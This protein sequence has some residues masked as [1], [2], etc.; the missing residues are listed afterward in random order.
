MFILETRVNQELG[1]GEGPDTQSNEV[2]TMP[3]K[4]KEPNKSKTNKSNNKTK[5]N[6]KTK[7]KP[8]RTRQH[9][10]QSDILTWPAQL[11]EDVYCTIEKIGMARNNKTKE[12]NQEVTSPYKDL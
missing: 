10:R 6:T 11:M 2:I 12:Q 7:T 5:K 8:T 4:S 3:I 9:E 1:A